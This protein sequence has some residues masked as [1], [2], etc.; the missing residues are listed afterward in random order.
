VK[1]AANCGAWA[2]G[3]QTK[4]HGFYVRRV[5][6]GLLM[7]VAEC[8]EG[9][10]IRAAIILVERHHNKR[11]SLPSLGLASAIPVSK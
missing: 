8:R 4:R 5:V 6:W 7:A 9:E 11:R 3:E 1:P 2:I 10:Q